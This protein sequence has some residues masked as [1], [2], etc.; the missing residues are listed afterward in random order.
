M[1]VKNKVYK[2]AIG[3]IVAHLKPQKFTVSSDLQC[4]AAS[5]QCQ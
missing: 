1:N 3:D 5:R 4:T 2:T